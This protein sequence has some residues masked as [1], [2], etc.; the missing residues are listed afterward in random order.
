MRS[1]R[2]LRYNIR[3]GF[4]RCWYKALLIWSYVAVCCVEFLLRLKI[5]YGHVEMPT[6]SWGNYLMYVI[7]GVAE[8]HPG[9]EKIEIPVRWLMLH[10]LILYSMADF[11][12][13]ELFHMG[14][15]TLVKCKS[16]FR[17]L[18]SKVEWIVLHLLVVYAG[19]L[20]VTLGMAKLFDAVITTEINFN[21]LNDLMHTGST[22]ETLGPGSL[23]GYFLIGTGAALFVALMQLLLSVWMKPILGF[24]GAIIW[25]TVSLYIPSVWM[26]GNILIPLRSI[27]IVENGYTMKE[28]IVTLAIQVPLLLVIGILVFRKYDLLEKK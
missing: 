8:F 24:A 2:L 20:V 19:I 25:L 17:W 11:P 4:W 18:I 21:V 1:T 22:Y 15:V 3:T 5:V 14:N 6:V 7:G 26:N 27:W 9:T 10:I 23:M 12:I 16:R 28:A 13:Y